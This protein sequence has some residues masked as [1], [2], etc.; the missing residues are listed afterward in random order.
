MVASK[1]NQKSESEKSQTCQAQRGQP[2]GG[3]SWEGSGC[4]NDGGVTQR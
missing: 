4:N 2:V 1:K 3:L